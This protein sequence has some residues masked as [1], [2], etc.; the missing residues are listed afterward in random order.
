M[1]LASTEPSG[2][3]A[4]AARLRAGVEAMQIPHSGSTVSRWLTVSFGVATC[5]PLPERQPEEL[6]E[7]ADR[8]LYAAKQRGRNRVEVDEAWAGQ[9]RPNRQSSG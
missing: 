9:S 4:I 8:A 6:V 5:V 3:K 2:A 7:C 1:I